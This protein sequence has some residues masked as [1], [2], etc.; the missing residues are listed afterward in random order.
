MLLSPF[1]HRIDRKNL[2]RSG[3]DLKSMDG[4]IYAVNFYVLKMNF[5][6]FKNIILFYFKLIFFDVFKL[7]KYIILIY[8]QIKSILTL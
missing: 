8:F 5:K 7:K 1:F 2:T 6:N 3:S 4:L